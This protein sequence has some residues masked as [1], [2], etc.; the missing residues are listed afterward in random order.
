MSSLKLNTIKTD[1]L[2]SFCES[3]VCPTGLVYR[4]E[5]VER[6]GLAETL[7]MSLALL[8]KQLPVKLQVLQALQI[9]SRTSGELTVSVLQILLIY[10]YSVVG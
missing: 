9:L 3:G 4:R 8:D 1:R 6:S 7:L 2:F 10:S 5:L